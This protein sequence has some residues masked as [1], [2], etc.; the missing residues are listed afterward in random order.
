[1][2]GLID[3]LSHITRATFQHDGDAVLLLG[4]MGGELG[5]SEY[6]ATIHDEVLGPPP[7]CNLDV[8]KKVIDSLLEA[9]R[10]GAVSSAHDCSDGGLAIALAE[11][12]IADL[13]CQSGAEIDLSTFGSIP[14]RG[15]LFGETQARIVVSSSA[16]ERVLAI[17]T[18]AGVPCARIGTVRRT[19]DSL[20]IK[21]ATVAIKAPLTRLRRAYHDT[22]PAIMSRTPE[23]ATFDELAPVAA[24]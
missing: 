6:L 24:H 2:V 3:N 21:L 14:D 20:A 12:C 19:S 22:I 7:R 17:A 16:P 8:E 15:V 13:E 1:M 18:H 4:E 9:I 5:G 23:H 11:C 10:A